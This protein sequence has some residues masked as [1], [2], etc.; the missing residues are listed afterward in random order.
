[1]LHSMRNDKHLATKLRR[2]GKSYKKIEKELGIPRSTLFGWFSHLPW[3]REMKVEL[4]RRANYV[5]HRKFRKYVKARQKMWEAWREAAR[6]EAR[7]DFP[8]LSKNPL[9]IAGIML[10]WG[11]GDSVLSNSSIRITNTDPRMLQLFVLFLTNICFVPLEKLRATIILYPDLREDICIT[12]W[13]HAIGIPQVQFSTT[14]Y[15][16]GRHPTRRLSYG[17]C[18]IVYGSRLLKEKIYVWL[19]LFHQQYGHHLAD[20]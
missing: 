19:D 11:E 1:M 14:Q 12:Y 18:Q 7:R 3:S 17:I 10:Y 5:N 2:Q 20:K 9:F 15:I 16:K 4:T 8:K 13:S 6:Q